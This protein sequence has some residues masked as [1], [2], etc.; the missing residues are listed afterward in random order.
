MSNSKSIKPANSAQT[1]AM[2]TGTSAA[3]K[4]ASF[5][6]NSLPAQTNL[7]K[8]KLVAPEEPAIAQLS[9]EFAK[10]RTSLRDYV[11]FLI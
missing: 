4:L 9:A 7:T 3:G 8:D 10:Q 1:P 5:A 6:A 2:R 11:Y